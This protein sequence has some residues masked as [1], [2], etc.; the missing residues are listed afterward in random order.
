MR[1]RSAAVA[2]V[3]LAAIGAVV[4]LAVRPGGGGAAPSKPPLVA[5]AEAWSGL[6]GEP[7]APVASGQRVLVVLSAFSLADQV[8]RAGGRASDRDERRWTATAAAAQQQFLAGLARRG[9][10]IKPEYRFTRTLNG[11]S[12]LVDAG[13][14]ALLER[15]PGVKGVYPVRVAFPAT[16]SSGP[17]SAGLGRQPSVGLAGLTGRGV[18]VALLDTGVDLHNPYLHGHVLDGFDVIGNGTDASPQAKPTDPAQLE[19]HG[20]EM[21]GLIVG[22]G[23]TA[24]AGGVAPG[25][26]ILPI[27]VAGWQTDDHGGYTVYA[28]ADQMLAGLERAVDPNADGDAHDAVRIAL[29]P[30]VEPFAAFSDSPLA[31]AVSGALS[32]DTLVVAAAGND[33]PG[34]PAFG[35]IGG[36]AGAP[37]ALSVGAFDARGSGSRSASS[38]GP[39]SACSSTAGSRSPAQLRPST[40]SC[41][42]PP[43]RAERRPRCPTSSTAA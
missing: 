35:S 30:L 6:V 22:V 7:H 40:R 38:H 33:G 34:G 24:G 14:I 29:I 25:A 11:F 37:D 2:V 31:R 13:A 43:P 42:G 4:G 16:V 1:W 28:R 21:A 9:V 32:L 20:T 26:T 8:Q 27:R 5:A 15:T 19:Q 10:Q 17:A 23:K 39:G 41:S 3:L 36:P 18:T 12:A